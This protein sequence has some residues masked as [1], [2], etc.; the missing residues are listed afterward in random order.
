MRVMEQRVCGVICAQRC[1]KRRNRNPRRLAARVNERYDLVADVFVEH[2]LPP[3]AMKRVRGLV[4]ERLEI[5]GADA[6]HFHAAGVDEVCNRVEEPMAL[7]L[8]LVALARRKREE[9]RAPMAEH[10]HAHV[11][12]EPRGIPVGV[13]C[14]HQAFTRA[15]A[16]PSYPLVP[17]VW[18]AVAVTR[19]SLTSLS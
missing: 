13:C 3:A 19:G 4:E 10:R 1:S 8:P 12:L 6:E 11:V 5:V 2:P 15:I 18:I 14:L 7:E 9:R 17:T 16:K